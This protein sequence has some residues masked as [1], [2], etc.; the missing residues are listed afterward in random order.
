VS[1]DPAIIKTVYNYYDLSMKKRIILYAATFRAGQLV[2][3]N[4]L[5]L[6]EIRKTFPEKFKEEYVLIVRL[7]P[8]YTEDKELILVDL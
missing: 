2:E 1:N 5:F 4:A 3:V 6:E 7:H 8:K